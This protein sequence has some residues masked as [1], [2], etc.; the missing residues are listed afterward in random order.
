LVARSYFLDLFQVGDKGFLKVIIPEDRC[1]MICDQKPALQDTTAKSGYTLKI[2]QRP[3]CRISHHS[4]DLWV[5]QVDLRLQVFVTGFYLD[6]LGLSV[7]RR[8]ALNY[9]GYEDL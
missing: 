5:Y 1:R 9:A 2:Q 8:A 4:D 7:E 6:T 3:S